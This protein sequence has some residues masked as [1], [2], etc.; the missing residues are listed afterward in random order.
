MPDGA[1]T[2]PV[3][4]DAK[5][6]GNGFEPVAV[7]GKRPVAT[8]WVSRPNTLEDI[9]AE[10]AAYPGAT[11]TGLRTGRTVGVDL[12][13]IPAAHVE[14]LKK[15]AH[16]VLGYTPM[17][18]LGSK[19]ALLVY[20]NSETPAPK[21]TVAYPTVD[22]VGKPRS[23]ALIEILGQGQQFVSYGQHPD[24]GQ[25]YEWV[26][27][28]LL[29]S[30]PLEVSLDALPPVTPEALREFA[31]EAT[32][33]LE[34]L[35]YAGARVTDRGLHAAAREALRRAER[36]PVTRDY[37]ERM[38]ALVPPGEDRNAWIGKLGGLQATNLFGVAEAHMDAVLLEIAVAWSR[39]DYCGVVPANWTCAEDV[40]HAYF[41]LRPDK[42]GGSGFGTL[43][44]AARQ[45]GWTERAPERATEERY[46][47]VLERHADAGSGGGG[48]A[49]P[50]N[51]HA[52]PTA[53]SLIALLRPWQLFDEPDPDEIVVDMIFE[54][55][56]VAIVGV[57]KS[58]KSFLAL[59]IALA[60]AT[61]GVNVGG[62]HEVKRHGP[63][64]YLSGEGHS[65][66]KRRI[67]AWA[68]ERGIDLNTAAVEVAPGVM[69]LR[70]VEFYYNKGVIRST[71]TD[72]EI[73]QAVEGIQAALGG[74]NPV[75]I[76]LDTVARSMGGDTDENGAAD[77]NR[78]LNMADK[79]RAP[80]GNP[81]F[82]SVIHAS[83]RGKKPAAEGDGHRMVSIRGS[84]AF[85]AGFDAVWVVSMNKANR[86]VRMMA[87]MLKEAD[88]IGPFYFRMR[89]VHIAGTPTTKKRNFTLVLDYVD[90]RE[91]VRAAEAGEKDG[92][93]GKVRRALHSRSIDGADK[94]WMDA[95]LAGRVT[96]MEKGVKPADTDTS[97]EASDWR[98]A[99]SQNLQGLHQAARPSRPKAWALKL[100]RVVPTPDGKRTYRVWFLDERP[101]GE[102]DDDEPDY[103]G[104]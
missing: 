46:K 87:S 64:I 81:A 49:D 82:L 58:G 30:E 70:D 20:R 99:Y 104:E 93:E 91:V 66:M 9:A 59:E 78:Y 18:R 94:G 85:D 69:R 62:Y 84:S 50:F 92:M 6:I 75:L 22:D 97:P 2:S 101:M 55:E 10:R 35:G 96:V 42:P 5:L 71:A 4:D 45:H 57:P 51:L 7:L 48:P 56:H 67:K 73:A 83:N 25:D 43:Y 60:I 34:G 1:F 28:D 40:E 80:L 86:T 13:V 54:G 52:P 88:D 95:D 61:A 38:L 11:N 90:P 74:R 41:S 89:T 47:E 102:P 27:T 31:Q 23:K 39:G 21:I 29:P 37:L 76:V 33:L 65:G 53:T 63:V 16:R 12:D 36:V 17:E 44:H 100:S 14:A 15:L 24:T 77:A 19:G 26:N 68:Q 103:A 32:A 72:A 98:L 79:L 8:G 3:T